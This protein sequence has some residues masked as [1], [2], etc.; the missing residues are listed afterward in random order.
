MGFGAAFVMPA[1]LSI[2]TNVF[3][4]QERAKAIAVWAGIAAGGAAL[5]PIASGFLL[6]H[7][8]WGS[9]FYVNVPIVL[10]A[11]VAGYFI[12]PTSRD[13]D[14]SKLDPPGA[15]LS[16]LGLGTLV[17]AIIEAPDHGW[18]SPETLLTFALAAI[19]LGAFIL[20]EMQV[21]PPHAEPVA[22]PRPAVPRRIRRH[23]PHVL[24]HVRDL[25]PADA[26]LPAGARLRRPRR[27]A[28]PTCPSPSCS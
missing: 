28:S 25:L 13:P 6:R 15:L 1:T 16:I 12:L 17:Y 8:S 23:A 20:W 22:V 11:L 3:P 10:A 14:E 26:V 18:G 19:I 5:G 24:R 2:I 9:V 27:P 7:F 4:A 21:Q